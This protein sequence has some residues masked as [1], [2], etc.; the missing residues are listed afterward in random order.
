MIGAIVGDIVGSRFEFDNRKSKDFGLF[1]RDCRPTDDSVMTLAI[2]DALL[3]YRKSGGD[4]GRHAVNKMRKWGRKYINA[5]YGTMFLSWL[6][7]KNP[8]PYGSWG[9]GAAMRVS[10]CGWAAKT[11]KEAL[12]F[13][14]A[15]TE[16]THNHPEA[17][18]AA[19]TIAA[20]V[21]FAR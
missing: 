18:K 7:D 16:V 5:G 3:E 4:L 21:F 20:L 8:R 14:R 11:Y 19:E 9:N 15:V 1:A 12:Q 10:I 13:A 6:M 2:G 17:I